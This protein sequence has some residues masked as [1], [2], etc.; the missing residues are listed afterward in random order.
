MRIWR[1][2]VPLV[3]GGRDGAGASLLWAKVVLITLVLKSAHYKK[4]H[5]RPR[6]SV[7][8]SEDESRSWRLAGLVRLGSTSQHLEPRI[9]DNPVNRTL[10]GSKR[11]QRYAT[12]RVDI[13]NGLYQYQ[14]AFL[15]SVPSKRKP[16][17]Q[18]QHQFSTPQL[19]DLKM[20][21]YID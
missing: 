16:P 6:S 2:T 1:E 3:G 18:K 13:R 5:L 19:S 15:T 7:R 17:H 9:T 20:Q 12:F 10:N 21:M 4:S 14:S 8:R 11:C